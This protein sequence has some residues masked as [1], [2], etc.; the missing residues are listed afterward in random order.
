MWDFGLERKEREMTFKPGPLMTEMMNIITRIGEE[1]K[2]KVVTNEC[3][4]RL[5]QEIDKLIESKNEIIVERKSKPVWLLTDRER[6]FMDRFGWEMEN[7]NMVKRDPQS[8]KVLAHE[9]DET[10]TRDLK[11]SGE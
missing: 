8:G 7:R 2:T 3:I 11:V 6:K 10:W 4:L 9:G 5:A 1:D